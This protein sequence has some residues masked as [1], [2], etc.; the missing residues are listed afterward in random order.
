MTT[1]IQSALLF[2]LA[3]LAV[4]VFASPAAAQ[5]ETIECGEYQGV[6]CQG[7]FTDEVGVVDDPQRIED[8]IS[9]IVGHYGNPIAVVIVQDSR[10]AD[11]ADFAAGLANAWGVGD[12]T[13]ENGILVLVSLDERRTE[14]VTQ[15]GVSVPGEAV[16]GSARSFFSAGDFEGG[17]LAIVGSVEQ[18]L[19]GTLT[20]QSDSSG[21]PIGAI[22][23]FGIVGIFIYS[24]VRR[25]FGGKRRIRKAEHN[26]REELIDADLADLEPSGA[27][28]PRFADYAE[29]TPAISD[30]STSSGVAELWRVVSGH[31]TD[32]DVMR[33]LWSLGLLEVV[34][35]ER[36]VADTR[37]P[38]DLR[39]SEERALLEGAV[40]EAADDALA[41]DHDDE[42]EFKSTRRNLNRLIA[43]LRPHRIAAARRRTGDALVADLIASPIGYVSTTSLGL[44]V[45]DASPAFSGDSP[46]SESVAEYRA[47]ST[48]AEV[49]IDRLERL[50]ERLPESTARPAV[51]AALADLD[52]DTDH[53]IERYERVRRSLDSEAAGLTADGLD[54]AA[55]AA[56]LLMNRNERN[57]QEFL[58]GYRRHRDRGFDPAE[59][60]EF[61]LA[62]LMTEGAVE[63]VRTVTRRLG[64][65]ISITAA[66]LERRDDGPKVYEHLRDELAA[67]T[68]SDSARTVAGVLAM[69]LEPSQAMRRWLEAREALHQLGLVG[70]Y[71]D[72]AAAFGASDPRG[73][74]QFALAYA[75][76][77]RVLSASSI[78]DADRFAPELAH[79]GTSGQTD[80]WSGDPI[81]AGIGS[82]DPFTFFFHHWVITR[83]VSDSYGWEPIYRDASWSKDRGS[84]W[85]GGGGFGSSGGSSWGGSSWGG[86]SFGGFSGGGGFSSSGG[87]GW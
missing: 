18:A 30:V 46:L 38:L 51:A 55:I 32:P 14:V 66:L 54:P 49:K 2:V 81:P 7:Y 12:P 76:Q 23:F 43:S 40:Q 3:F 45:A 8:A 27:D 5:R 63:R 75:A 48:E 39:V 47:F 79:A 72:V 77:R 16:A 20:E 44:A 33:S 15:D 87:G 28:L 11:P 41:V 62:G 36:L 85:G 50:Y 53:A 19:A 56:L 57:T 67:Y 58:D 52:H 37:E 74:R 34:D 17:L 65:P 26:K 13:E 22:V 70:S 60:V 42:A 59:A 71:A 35:R 78:D 31:P 84:W 29:P 4:A 61:A 1:S 73:S 25:V 24:V 80:T 21:S 9:R 82:F 6:V 83:G 69:S 64:L 10:G 86:G 68:S